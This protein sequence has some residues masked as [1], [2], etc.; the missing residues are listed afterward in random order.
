MLT[1]RQHVFNDL[2]LVT[3]QDFPLIHIDEFKNKQDTTQYIKTSISKSRSLARFPQI[4]K[5]IAETLASK[6]QGMFLWVDL[7]IR[8]LGHKTRAD[9]VREALHKAP[10]GL[11]EM[12]QTV[13]GN[14]SMTFDDEQEAGDF[15]TILSWVTCASVPLPLGVIDEVLRI[16]L[17]NGEGISG[18]EERLRHEWGV[19]LELKRNDGLTTDDLESH[20]IKL[21]ETMKVIYGDTAD[22]GEAKEELESAFVSNPYSTE[23]IFCHASIGDIFRNGVQ[24][25]VSAEDRYPAVGVDISKAAKETLHECLKSI[26]TKPPD[27]TIDSPLQKYSVSKWLDHV[28]LACKH[29]EC[30]ETRL[31]EATGV[32]LL[33]LFQDE[34]IMKN[35]LPEVSPSEFNK[36]N[37]EF[38]LVIIKTCTTAKHISEESRQWAETIMARPYELFLPVARFSAK[39]WL[40]EYMWKVDFCLQVIYNVSC[41]QKGN[42]VEKGLQ[43]LSA[44]TI[45]EVAEST[46]LPQNAE[47]HRRIAMCFAQLGHLQEA[48]EH[49]QAA[50]G[51]DS[52]NWLAPA[53]LGYVEKKRGQYQEALRLMTLSSEILEKIM[54]FQSLPPTDQQK[55]DLA[56]RY[57]DIAET[58]LTDGDVQ[59]ALRYFRKS[60]HLIMGRQQCMAQ[61]LNA[62]P[63]ADTAE[64]VRAFKTLDAKIPGRTL[65]YATYLRSFIYQNV[66]FLGAI[67]FRKVAGAFKTEG[68]IEW[69]QNAYRTL[70]AAARKDRLP[71]LEFLFS[72][73]LADI[74]YFYGGKEENAMQIWRTVLRFPPTFLSSNKSLKYQHTY[75]GKTYAQCLVTNAF[76]LGIGTQD[77]EKQIR[78][79][80]EYCVSTYSLVANV[81][82]YHMWPMTNI[83]MGIWKINIGEREAGRAWLLP[84][85]QM[86][87]DGAYGDDELETE[88][89]KYMT[90]KML[91]AFGDEAKAVSLLQSMSWTRRPVFI[92]E[93]RCGVVHDRW[94]KGYSCKICFIDLCDSCVETLKQGNQLP[95]NICS[96]DHSWIYVQGLS[97]APKPGE[98][99]YD[100][101]MISMSQFYQDLKR[102]WQL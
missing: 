83:V 86:A 4:Q 11:N 68:E 75:I 27:G 101:Q 74:F 58:A 48:E 87:V 15:N 36:E 92:C 53:G 38:L 72:I 32:T 96:P 65:D 33:K 63:K 73:A 22:R 67:S 46:G 20:S 97:T 35:W 43:G 56:R 17:G 71:V 37:L 82:S 1:G 61:Y 66:T 45:L 51:L 28:K 50:I 3:D 21:H 19:L 7:M 10:K 81:P 9:R 100:G 41:L 42:L 95:V 14:Y 69:L 99:Y 24:A 79:L 55:H 29:I 16:R 2:S 64:L 49:Y 77:A 47:W 26:C 80:E 18:L 12:V 89:V 91:I 13:L 60:L 70:I 62:L 6:S 52:R 39:Q 102:D 90:A 98:I 44:K 93:G 5:D 94:Q 59:S 57:E 84:F 34:S 23:V 88:Q 85:M 8:D 76:R 54:E 40:Q 30:V 25:K 31:H 78:L